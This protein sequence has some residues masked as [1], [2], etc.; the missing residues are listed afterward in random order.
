VARIKDFNCGEFAVIKNKEPDAS[1]HRPSNHR[2]PHISPEEAGYR[3]SASGNAGNY[4]HIFNPDVEC[5]EDD[6]IPQEEKEPDKSTQNPNVWNPGTGI[7][8]HKVKIGNNQYKWV[9]NNS[10]GQ[11]IPTPSNAPLLR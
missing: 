4:P 5:R 3:S 9:C 2:P 11:Q 10:K 7:I 1:W 8:C 6:Y